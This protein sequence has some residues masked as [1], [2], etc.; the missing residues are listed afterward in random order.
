[1]TGEGIRAD[2]TVTESDEE[3]VI[4]A[5]DQALVDQATANY[6]AYVED[7]SA[8]LLEKTRSSSSSTSPATTTRPGRSTPT[9]A[10]TGSGSRPWPSRSATST[11]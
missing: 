5:D 4:D 1:M 2:F 3:P 9:P 11:R 6:A 7:Q 10:C 8:Q